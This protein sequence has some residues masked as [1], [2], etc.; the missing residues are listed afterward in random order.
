MFGAQKYLLNAYHTTEVAGVNLTELFCLNN[1][2][3][4]E[5][6]TTAIFTI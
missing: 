1:F 5:L 4:F 2:E 3:K 6:K